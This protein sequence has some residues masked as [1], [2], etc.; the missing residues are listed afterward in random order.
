MKAK[1]TGFTSGER[2]V[3]H[4]RRIEIYFPDAAL[5]RDVISVPLAAL[6]LPGLVLDDEVEVTFE[7]PAADRRSGRKGEGGAS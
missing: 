6:G 3:D 7:C 4:R 2:F 1:V 5:G